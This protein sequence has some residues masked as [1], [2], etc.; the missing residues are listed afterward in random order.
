MTNI[1]CADNSDTIRKI[2][3]DCVEDLG[4]TFF[5]AENGK[6]CITKA[7]E[8]DHLRM[9]I[10]DWNMPVV[11]GRETLIT[12]RENKKFKDVLILVLIKLENKDQVMNVIDLG[13][14]NY[15]LKPFSVNKLQ[16]K[17]EEIINDA[18]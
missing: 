2:V 4:Y 1:L 17:I 8:M 7:N 18:V 11:S 10:L 9:I 6:D 5:E 3:K 13:A 15:M 16:N 14:T 12:L